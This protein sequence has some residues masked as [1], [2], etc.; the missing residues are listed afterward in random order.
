M[1]WKLLST[2]IPTSFTEVTDVLLAN[3]GI[4]NAASFFAPKHPSELT[5]KDV[6][7]SKTELTKALK[8]LETA[9]TE[10]Q[11]V[12][13][14]GDYDADGVCATAIMWLGL[15]A[16]GITAIPFIPLRDK[17][18][19]GLSV[20]ALAEI[21]E[22]HAP[23]LII[24]VDNGIVA[25][26][27]VTYAKKHGCSVV[28][29]D[30]HQADS[31]TN[32][33]DAVV[34]TTQLCGATVA[35]MLVSQLIGNT[36][37]SPLL[38]LAALAT[39]ADQVT[40]LDANRSFAFHGIQVLRQT[41]RKGIKA[42]LKVAGVEQ[43]TITSETI[44]FSIVPRINAMGRL[45]HG[46]DAL[47][48]LCSSNQE[49]VTQL[50]GV[51]SQTNT[52]RQLLTKDLTDAALDEAKLQMDEHVIIVASNNYHE[53]IIGL[54]AGKLVQEFSKPAIVLSIAQ[55]TM[56]ASVRSVPGVD[57][58]TFLR[59]FKEYM[60]SLGGH[61]MAA[62]FGVEIAKWDA[63]RELLFVGA[64]TQIDSA[65]LQPMH[66]A[67]CV[68]NHA[69][70]SLDLVDTLEQFAPHGPGN[71]YPTFL[72]KQMTV[73]QVK[74]VG[75]FGGHLHC[76]VKLGALKQPLKL[77]GWGMGTQSTSFN[78]GDTIDCIGQL[79]K[80]TWQGRTSLQCIVSAL[81]LSE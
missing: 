9:K 48:L 14:F 75:K 42:L 5:L 52:Q 21:I 37:C 80:N 25:H 29:T 66:N 65:L 43:E 33:A 71:M 45:A 70:V 74:A 36:N 61:S 64:S 30:H 69:L 18:G 12:V 53:G 44:G 78:P 41:P 63:L 77:V 16:H 68:L 34:H 58:V 60:T 26:E 67:D 55:T 76:T 28:I 6:G 62:G 47:R 40:L 32:Q 38:D 56:K 46:L 20:G 23:Q 10:N 73:E 72:I 24:T 50:A 11:K 7:I 49:R 54:L 57:I 3:R 81:R 79:Q 59:N 22:Q 1:Q 35:Y 13:I 51:L 39:I 17:H 31:D 27:A 8:I 15:K 2:T 19:Y 4:T